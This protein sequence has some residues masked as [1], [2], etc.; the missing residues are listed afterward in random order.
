MSQVV[1]LAE[2]A[3]RAASALGITST[4]QRNRALLVMAHALTV[5]QDEIL[6][7][8]AADMDAARAKG[9]AEGLLDRLELTPARLKSIGAS[10]FPAARPDRRGCRGH[11]LPS[12]IELRQVRVPRRGR[13]HL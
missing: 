9:T 13:H 10:A 4:E 1:E 2:R 11:T 7:A 8:N 3:R 12:G 6:A 5:K